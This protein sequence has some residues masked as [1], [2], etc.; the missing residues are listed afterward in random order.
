M[1]RR[2]I[3]SLEQALS[4]PYAT[5][6]FAQLGWR[7]IRIEATP[8][9][10]GLPGDPNRY[11]GSNILDNDRR[12]YFIAA[13][14]GKEAIALNLKDKRGQ[15]ILHK[16]I[17]DLDVDVFCCNTLPSRYKS[18]GIDYDRLK[19]VKPDIIWAGIS[20]LGPEYPD[21]PG[22]DPIV[23][24]MCGIMELTGDPEGPPTLCGIPLSDLKAGDEV[25]GQVALALAERAETG[26]GKRIDVSMFQ[27]TASWLITTLPLL[28][29]D[30]DPLEITRA[31]SQHRKFIPTDTFE[32][33]DGYIYIAVGN[34]IQWERL[35]ALE[36]FAPASTPAR[37]QNEGRHKEREAMFA[38]LH[39]ITRQYS[40]AEL[41]E[42]LERALVPWSVINSVPQVAVHDA[43]KKYL[44]T[45]TVPGGQQVKMQPPA[46]N[47]EG[48]TTDLSFSPR[49]GEHTDSL[50]DEIGFTAADVE[51]YK[52]DGVVVG[53]EYWDC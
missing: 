51:D 37:F 33:K 14:V 27:A 35:V 4:L 6:R 36:K 52:K 17:G 29:F 45:T 32:T 8:F 23:Q 30:P 9:G 5:M 7:V 19:T 25:F 13:T 46:V 2:T 40:T 48:L 3:I 21:V 24:A 22:Y 50:L 31:G 43:I 18:L 47:L 34:D 26:N 16:L 44:T 39:A 41:A 53:S 15:A 42:D 10:G 38:D 49:Y 20:A 1:A 28:N 11:I 12:S